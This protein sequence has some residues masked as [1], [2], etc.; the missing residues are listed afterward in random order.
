MKKRKVMAMLLS[1]ILAGS[2]V[3]CGGSDGRGIGACPQN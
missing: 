1:C 3:A 2:L